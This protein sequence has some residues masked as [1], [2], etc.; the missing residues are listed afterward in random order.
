VKIHFEN[1]VVQFSS[2]RS[3]IRPKAVLGVHT[4]HGQSTCKVENLKM[5]FHS[6]VR[7][8]LILEITNFLRLMFSQQFLYQ[9]YVTQY[10]R[11]YPTY[12]ISF[13]VRCKIMETDKYFCTIVSDNFYTNPF[14]KKSI[15]VLACTK[16]RSHRYQRITSLCHMNPVRMENGK[17]D[18]K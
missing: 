3:H 1:M 11:I 5:A 15:T 9:P 14:F 7:R 13:D 10:R 6:Y 8:L 16:F 18:R 2:T 4:D 17:S 12:N